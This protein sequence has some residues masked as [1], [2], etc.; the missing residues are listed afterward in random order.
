M[1]ACTHALTYECTYACT[2]AELVDDHLAYLRRPLCCRLGLKHPL[3]LL[4]S[5]GHLRIE[6]HLPLGPR[7][8]MGLG[9][10]G[11]GEG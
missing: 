3:L 1:C 5:S 8:R 6:R 7:H 2:Y 9:H 10:L 4:N 11:E